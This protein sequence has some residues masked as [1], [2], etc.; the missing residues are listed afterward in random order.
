MK[1]RPNEDADEVDN[2]QSDGADDAGGADNAEECKSI[3]DADGVENDENESAATR[4]GNPNSRCSTA[5]KLGVMS[6]TSANPTPQS[7]RQVQQCRKVS[8]GISSTAA[9]PAQSLDGMSR[10]SGNPVR[11]VMRFC[12]IRPEGKCIWHQ[13]EARWHLIWTLFA[14]VS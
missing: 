6:S 2:K 8:N 13:S 11:N 14:T 7:K 5:R 9:N 10:S 1:A 3:V 12:G 4:A